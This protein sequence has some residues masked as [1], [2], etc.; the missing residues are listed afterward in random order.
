MTINF[1]FNHKKV[2]PIFTYIVIIKIPKII[3]KYPKRS[4]LYFNL[5]QAQEKPLK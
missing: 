2:D 4:H 1:N 3:Q 5:S